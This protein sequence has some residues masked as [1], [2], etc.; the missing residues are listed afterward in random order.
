MGFPVSHWVSILFTAM[1][2]SWAM[3]P[4]VRF[5]ERAYIPRAFTVLVTYLAFFG[6]LGAV[7]TLVVPLIAEQGHALARDLPTRL[8]AYYTAIHDFIARFSPSTADELSQTINELGSQISHQ[9][10]TAIDTFSSLVSHVISISVDSLLVLV[11]AFFL[12]IEEGSIKH[13]VN[14]FVK[15]AHRE[16]VAQMIDRITFETG[17]WSSAQLMLAMFFGFAFGALLHYMNVP[18]ATTIG[19]VG[20]VLDIIPYGGVIALILAVIIELQQNWFS[21]LMLIV[22]YLAIVEVEWH[23][24]APPLLDRYLHLKNVIIVLA[25]AIGASMMGILGALLSLP[26]AIVLRAVL[27][28][29]FPHEPDAVNAGV[30]RFVRPIKHSRFR[31]WRNWVLLHL[32]LRAQRKNQETDVE[33]TDTPVDSDS[34]LPASSHNQ[35]ESAPT[36]V[37][38]PVDTEVVSP[39]VKPTES[40]TPATK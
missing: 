34:Q 35:S 20:G 21:A 31:P 39:A 32:H 15:P 14:R 1:V 2:L 8:P 4:L 28:Y 3:T 6:V 12:T 18:Y 25:L 26:M 37:V 38:P 24:L 5:L 9:F 7:A 10:A 19:F 11:I 40:E 29:W 17:R 16:D 13:M 36:V 33:T 30:A 22:G 23:V 27:D